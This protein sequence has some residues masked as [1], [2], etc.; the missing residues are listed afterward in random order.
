MKALFYSQ[1]LWDL[2]DNG[3]T[4]SL[5]QVAYNVYHKHKM[6]FSMRIR[7]RMPRRYF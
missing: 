2:V 6:I 7:R 3:F 4:E 1:E 5:D